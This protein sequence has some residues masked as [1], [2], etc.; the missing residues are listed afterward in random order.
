MRW[1]RPRGSRRRMSAS[2]RSASG[3]PTRISRSA[4]AAIAW[5]RWIEGPRRSATPRACARKFGVAPALIPDFLALVGDAQDGYPGHRGHRRRRAARL[6]NRYGA[7]RGVPGER[8]RRERERR[9]CS[10]CWRRSG[11]T[12]RCFGTWRSSGGGGRRSSSRRGRAAGG[13]EADGSC[14]GRV[15]RRSG[16]GAWCSS[17]R[18]AEGR[19]SW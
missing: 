3:R 6:L 12:R 2:R 10:R 19:S 14:G 17:R 5:C 18:A 13:E 15:Q 8:A 9:C 1:P 7:D 11:P 16:A 4:S